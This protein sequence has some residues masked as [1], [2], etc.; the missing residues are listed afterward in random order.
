MGMGVLPRVLV[1]F[2]GIVFRVAGAFMYASVSDPI[3]SPTIPVHWTVGIS[4]LGEGLTRREDSPPP[5]STSRKLMPIT[6]TPPGLRPPPPPRGAGAVVAIPP[7][8]PWMGLYDGPGGGLRGSWVHHATAGRIRSK[9]LSDFKKRLFGGQK[10]HNPLLLPPTPP[11]P[12]T[13]PLSPPSP[14]IT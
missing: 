10:T 9:R 7:R 8:K 13:A 3:R 4:P 5:L 6:P 14:T 1:F 12:K 2:M 11:E